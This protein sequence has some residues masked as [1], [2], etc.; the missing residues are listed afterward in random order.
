MDRNYKEG[1]NKTFGR[2]IAI[3]LIKLYQFFLSPFYG[4]HCRYLPT[5]SEYAYE[6]IARHG[7][8][9][10][11]WL[12]LFRLIRCNPCGCSGY[13]PVIEELPDYCYWFMPWRYY[14][15]DSIYR[16]NIR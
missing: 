14:K 7:V 1:Y 5:C 6:A 9:A 2:S 11:G 12:T 15:A 4:Q 10:G 3:S 13:H 16:R 8:W